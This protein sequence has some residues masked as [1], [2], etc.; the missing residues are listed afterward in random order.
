MNNS[1]NLK[2]NNMNAYT[3]NINIIKSKKCNDE[4]ESAVKN[5]I[6]EYYFN[7]PIKSKK[8]FIKLVSEDFSVP[9]YKEYNNLLTINYSVSQLKLIAKYHKL[10][11]TGNKEYLKKRL[12]NYLYFSYNIINIQKSV[13]YNLTNKYIKLHGPGFYNKTLCSNDIDFC[14]LDNL[15]NIPYNQFISFKDD[16]DHIYGFD[17][18]SLYNLFMKVTKNNK[19]RTSSE[20]NSASSNL[21]NVQNP[22]TNIFFSYN[23]LKQ[24]LEYI[25][26]SNLL[27]IHIDLNYDDLAHLSINKQAEMKILTLFQRIDSLGNYTNIKWFLELDK[28][29]L[30]RFIRE[31]VDIWNYRANLSQET[32]REIVPPRGNPFYDEHLNVNN[33]PQ[34]NFTQIRKYSIT[35]IDLMINKGINEN[36][37][38]LGSY[39]V[40]CALTM[41]SS[42]AANTLPWLYE[43]VNV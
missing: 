5:N 6:L 20:L 18:L 15:N 13:R 41:V 33:L 19:T 27:K 24:L 17:I 11:T 39:Y 8:A 21:L 1:N 35:I 42:D 23:V 10:K 2:V 29:G 7:L 25:R 22:F 36:S 4:T 28:Y 16:N 43:A 14:T 30:I 32:K 37:C 26:L 3:M 12:Y 31:L 38:L 9:D 40:L 34:Y